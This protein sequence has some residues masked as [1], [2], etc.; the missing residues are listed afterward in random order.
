MKYDFVVIGANGIQGRIV[1]RGLLEDGHSVLLC[2]IDDYK[3]EKIIDHPKADFAL[4]DLRKM[5]RVK[6]VVKK[7][8]APIVVNCAVD[9][10]NLNVTKMALELGMHY[11]D[12][13]SEEQMFY[14]QLSLDK[15]FKEKGL[16]GVT[17]IGS[18]PGITN[19]MLRH[20]KPEFDTIHTVHVGFAWDSNMQ[21]FVTPFS[22]DA[23]AYEFSEPAKLLENGE[24]VLRYPDEAN[25]DYYYKSIG[26]QKTRYTKHIEH[27]SYYEYLK[28]VGIKNI[29]VFSSFPPHSYVALKSLVDLGFT[30][31]EPV[32]V[33]S[34]S[35]KPL[36]FTIEA[37]RKIP[38]PEGY[39]EKENLFL[40][41]IGTKNGKNKTIEMDC[42]A[43]TQE[44]WEEH[45]CNVDTGFPAVI[46]AE[47]IMDG[48]IPERGMFSPEDIVPPEPFFQELAK[49]KLSVY[50]DGEKIN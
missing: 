39:T 14:E 49:R 47:M 42:V 3:M 44:G 5:E 25:V 1:S 6:R 16:T 17:G 41:V 4:I 32:Q 30:T 12:L 35:I 20:I 19:V 29:A 2:A 33:D 13:G 50:K 23:I 37:M 26:K 36:D 45:T 21:V 22:I 28:D 18:T 38:V 10:Y 27:H 15:E 34:A 7:A 46:L 31:K 43:H 48:R 24:Y 9:D 11:I 8:A 40:K